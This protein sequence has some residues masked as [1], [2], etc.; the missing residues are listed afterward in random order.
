MKLHLALRQVKETCA[1]RH[2]SINTEKTYLHWIGRYATFL[3][4]KPHDS[5][6]TERK[7]EAF[8]TSLALTGMSGSTQNQAFNAL[9]FFYRDVLKKQLGPVESLRAKPAGT[10]RQA[11]TQEEVRHLLSAVT[12]IYGY[13]TRL[14]V[15]LLYACGLRVSEPLNLRLKDID[16]KETRLYLY[17]ANP[18]LPFAICHLSF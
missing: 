16:F 13:P 7:M 12:D 10:V 3:K 11:P 15:H 1:L 17:Q 14:I 8:L 4:Q 5:L 6:P 18:P 2:L 9:L